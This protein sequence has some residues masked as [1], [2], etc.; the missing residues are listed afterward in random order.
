MKNKI[1]TILFL[2]SGIFSAVAVTTPPLSWHNCRIAGATRTV[3]SMHRSAASGRMYLGTNSGL[4]SF[5]GFDA[6]AVRL[7]EDGFHAQVYAITELPDGRCF[8]GTN[9][10]LFRLSHPA[11]AG[12]P[13]TLVP[14]SGP[15]PEEI[16]TMVWWNSELW[17]GSLRGLWRYDPDKEKTERVSSTSLSHD[18]VYALMPAP[19]GR[20]LF[21]GT[22]DGL[23]CYDAFDEVFT[24][25]PLAV[26]SGGNTFVNALAILQSSSLLLV[27]TEKGLIEFDMLSASSRRLTEFD[28][29]GVKALAVDVSARRLIAG[30][31]N[32]L[33]IINPAEPNEMPVQC[34]HDSRNPTSLANNVVWS[35]FVDPYGNVWAGTEM[36]VSIANLDSPV[37]A[38]SLADITNRFDGQQVYS[39]L[40][41][42]HG[43]F[44]LGGTNGVIRIP[45]GAAPAQWFMPGNRM[46]DLS[47]SRVRRIYESSAGDLLVAGD[48]GLNRFDRAKGRFD[49]YRITDSSHR[50]MANWI[51]GVVEDTARAE[52]WTGSYLGGVMATALDKFRPGGGTVTAD[53]LLKCSN[54]SAGD[55]ISDI[56][57]DIRGNKWVLLF[58]DSTVY[59]I[60][61][62]S[63]IRKSVDIKDATGYYPTAITR[64]R[65]GRIWVAHSYGAVMLGA[66]GSIESKVDFSDIPSALENEGVSAFAPVGKEI[67]VA[68]SDGVRAIDTETMTSRMLSLPAK[69]YTSIYYDPKKR[70]AI[71]GAVDELIVADPAGIRSLSEGYGHVCI[72]H[73]ETAEGEVAP[74]VDVVSLPYGRNSI[75]VF[76]TAENISGMSFP[77]F[78]YRISDL[79]S[80]WTILAEGDNRI[81]LSALPSGKHRLEMQING[82]ADSFRHININ[83]ASPWFMTWPAIAA[84]IFI[85]AFI[86]SVLEFNQR[87]RHR[88]SLEAVERQA[89]LEQVEER[90]SFLTN[91]SHELKT[92]LS[93]IIGPLSRLR[94]AAAP[95]GEDTVRHNIDV[96]YDAAIRLNELI[97]RTVEI[98]RLDVPTENMLIYSRIDAVEFCRSIFESYREAYPERHFVFSSDDASLPAEV[99]AV[100]LESI[101]NN[102]LSN[103]VKYSHKDSTISCSVRNFGP[104]M[105]ISVS[106][107]GIGIPLSEQKLIFQRLYR[108]S[109]SSDMSEGTG[110]GLYLV[111][112]Y[113]EMHH[114]RVSLHSRLGEGATFVIELPRGIEDC[115]TVNPPLIDGKSADT[116]SDKR[117]RVLVVDDNA[118]IAAL[119]CDMLSDDYN[120]AV[121]ANGRAALA[122]ASTFH[123]D[124]II[125]DEMMPVMTGLEM[126]RSIKSNPMLAHTPIILLTAKNGP[127]IENESIRSGVEMFMSKPFEASKLRARVSQMIQSKE[128]VRRS[129]RIESMTEAKPI[130]AESDDERR[131]ASVTEIIEENISNPD[132]NVAFLC[133]KASIHQKQ[134]Y[135]LLKKYVGL[136]PVD[137]IRQTRLRKAAMLLEQGKF[138]VSEVMYMV[139]FS[140]SSYFSRC[141]AALYGCTPGQYK[142]ENPTAKP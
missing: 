127:D 136:S 39:M 84:Y 58:R 75:D 90:L 112:H 33:L 115:Q 138:S 42:S 51:Y 71:L 108:S 10:G 35:L 62:H 11:D 86:V 60:D 67:W 68:L 16:R 83:V 110:I 56:V 109:A 85:L 34:R 8:I 97:H 59:C 43:D 142:G 98:N 116:A 79:D 57:S 89:A 13:E 5:D 102:L 73:I 91:I 104:D 65:Q 133:E 6:R 128:N 118:A 122:V 25:L 88:R 30:T 69:Q 123:P 140:S 129:A 106:D 63:G 134:L 141:F 29:Y 70:R 135:R 46:R 47:H 120:C 49:N 17:I 82:I 15:F 95:V 12:W 107:D 1:L 130:E 20:R 2:V 41:D 27:G 105:E 74:D 53:S 77:R 103:A 72:S 28:G 55:L 111:K 7:G 48:G 22:Y 132:M 126:S 114:G 24:H 80:T 9:N 40:R 92:P 50:Y 23:C 94:D 52:L 19:D 124:L 61:A 100:K 44:W 125:A 36:G 26:G 32:G 76:L 4:F 137:Y 119:V 64:D 96:A 66:D 113:V 37:T 3:Y 38:V 21:I 45:D 131:L 99:D 54:S 18:A 81:R 31:E 101:L 78:R 14:A 121:A 87:R 139:G 117:P 93:M